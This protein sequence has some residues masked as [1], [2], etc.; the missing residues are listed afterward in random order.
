MQDTAC[1]PTAAV[2][3]RQP[4]ARMTAP[5]TKLL[6]L[7]AQTAVL[8]S[9]ASGVAGAS[10]DSE[11]CPDGFTGPNCEPCV[12]DVYTGECATDCNTFTTCNGHGRCRGWDGTCIC[13]EGW[14]GADCNVFD[15]GV[16]C[17]DGFT[18]PN[19]EPCVRDVYTGEC[20]VSCTALDTCSGHVRCRGW[21]GTCI[22]N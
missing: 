19:C 3:S 17:P 13:N 16:V 18:G 2:P 1:L 21:V 6:W 14:S 8:L 9:L 5:S 11:S 20:Q 7:C 22:C 15:S 12:R 4:E 10:H